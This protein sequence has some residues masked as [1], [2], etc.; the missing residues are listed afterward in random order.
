MG[1]AAA[2]IV[3]NREVPCFRRTRVPLVSGVRGSV[4]WI[5]AG[6]LRILSH[7]SCGRVLLQEAGMCP[8]CG[9]RRMAET[10]AHLVDRVPPH[11]PM[12]QWVLS[13]PHGL[14]HRMAYD[15]ELLSPVMRIFSRVVF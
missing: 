6:P 13:V 3:R 1:R 4:P 11:V 7:G 14:R 8:S 9:G 5:S 10:A 12:R 2:L 15:A